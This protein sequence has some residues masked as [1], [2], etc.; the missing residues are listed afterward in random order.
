MCFQ[1][2]GLRGKTGIV[3]CCLSLRFRIHVKKAKSTAPVRRPATT[4]GAIKHAGDTRVDL[5]GRFAICRMD[6]DLAF[7]AHTDAFGAN[8]IHIF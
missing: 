1:K 6:D 3:A 4:G 8:T 7:F 2:V 5:A